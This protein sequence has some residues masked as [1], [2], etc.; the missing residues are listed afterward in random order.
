MMIVKDNTVDLNGLRPEMFHAWQVANVIFYEHGVKECVLTSGVDG[1]HGNGSL[2]FVGLAI[3]IRSKPLRPS[4]HF[5]GTDYRDAVL[6]DIC[7]ALGHQYDAI[8]EHR[9][10]KY[11]H[12]HIEFQPKV[13]TP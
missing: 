8:L 13:Q 2:H 10:G 12:F 1:K 4:E 6:T 5:K 11:E 3:D 9:D 7:K